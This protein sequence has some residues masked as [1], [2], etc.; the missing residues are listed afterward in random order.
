MVTVQQQAAQVTRSG[1]DFLVRLPLGGFAEPSDAAVKAVARP[2]NDGV[3]NITSMMFPAAGTIGV[4]RQDLGTARIAYTIA[5]QTTHARIDPGFVQA[6]S[7]AATFGGVGLRIDQDDRHSEQRLDRYSVDGALSGE[8]AGR[9]TFASSS[10]AENWHLV[11]H[12]PDG[13]ETDANARA[14]A[15]HVTV[16]GLDRVQGT[17]LLTATRALFAEAQPAVPTPP[18]GMS[19]AQRDALRAVIDAADGLLTRF[20]ADQTI[21]GIRFAF[22]PL[23]SGS[24]GR[25][26]VNM[27][28]DTAA[29]RLTGQMDIA[30]DGLALSNL[31]A[32]TAAYVPHHVDLKSTMAGVPIRELMAF[33]RAATEADADPAALQDRLL[34]LFAKPGAQI[35]IESVAFELG[36]A[37]ADWIGAGCPAGRRA[38]QRSRSFVGDRRGCADRTGAG[39]A[40][41]AASVAD[42]VHGQGDGSGG[43]GCHGLGYRLG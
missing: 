23:A 34:Q 1:A 20:E 14:L 6:S 9:L 28:G 21:D 40:G 41:I 16:E 42:D 26:H 2:L 43:G 39:H 18:P 24:M 22:G 29:E 35:G 32:E 5:E 10:R 15:G 30:V 38:D 4:D 36:A 13:I 31:S 11:S 19:V 37:T 8:T 12:G 25:L 17:R 3:W 33:M 27:R 7:F